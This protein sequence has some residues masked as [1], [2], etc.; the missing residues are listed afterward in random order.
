MTIQDHQNV[1][2]LDHPNMLTLDHP[3]MLTLGLPD[4]MMLGHPLFHPFIPTRPLAPVTDGMSHIML[5][6]QVY[7]ADHEYIILLCVPHYPNIHFRTELKDAGPVPRGIEC[8]ADE[9]S[10]N[11]LFYKFAIGGLV[12]WVSREESQIHQFSS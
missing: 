1:L 6:S 4:V 5:L 7:T 9:E 11:C 2:T 3:N 12:K 8:A 10:A